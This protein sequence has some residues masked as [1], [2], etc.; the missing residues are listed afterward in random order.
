V[1]LDGL[2]RRQKHPPVVCARRQEVLRTS[3]ILEREHRLD[4][5]RIDPA[6]AEQVQHL[7]QLAAG[8]VA[9]ADDRELAGEDVD[10]VELGARARGG[11]AEHDP[12]LVRERAQRVPEDGLADV[13]DDQVDAVPA[14][15]PPHLVRPARPGVVERVLDAGG[16]RAPAFVLGRRRREHTRAGEARQ[17]DCSSADARPRRRHECRLTRPQGRP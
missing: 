11:A 12:P 16:E 3:G 6:L 14:R 4:R 8:A 15:Q 10:Q 13:V 9:R 5:R 1:R 7:P 2:R 17:R